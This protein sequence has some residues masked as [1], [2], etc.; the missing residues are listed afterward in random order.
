MA[1]TTRCRSHQQF[2]MA[3]CLCPVCYDRDHSSTGCLGTAACSVAM[4]PQHPPCTFDQDHVMASRLGSTID[5][6]VTT[7]HISGCSVEGDS[8]PQH[9]S[10]RSCARA[11]CCSVRAC[12]Q[13]WKMGLPPGR[14]ALYT[15]PPR[16]QIPGLEICAVCPIIAPGIVPVPT[17]MS[18]SGAQC[19][20]ITARKTC[21]L[22][23]AAKVDNYVLYAST[24]TFI[25]FNSVAQHA[26]WLVSLRLK[27]HHVKW[28]R[29]RHVACDGVCTSGGGGWQLRK[30]GLVLAG[31]GF[32]LAPVRGVCERR[33]VV[34]AQLDDGT[35]ML[36]HS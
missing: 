1:R 11:R 35:N 17:F 15:F 5:V 27:K 31:S 33:R 2:S 3:Y 16:F 4:A 18:R 25:E 8:S 6:A 21:V 22:A 28:L 10:G 13:R 7:M 20:T 9:Q 29:P 36:Q 24:A 23:C 34:C 14:F 19:M 30:P 12:A 32:C 26:A